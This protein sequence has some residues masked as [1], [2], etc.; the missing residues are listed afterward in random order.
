MM[1]VKQLNL[2]KSKLA[3]HNLCQMLQKEK[4]PSIFCLQEP[5]YTKNGLL[6]GIPK[7]Y[8]WFGSSNSRGII[9]AH[10]SIDLIYSNEFSAEDI[11]VCYM[12]SS[13]RFF[14]SIYLDIHKDPIHP[15]MI[16]MAEY[17]AVSKSSALLCLDSNAHSEAFWNSFDT[18]ARGESIELFC[19]TYN[20]YVLNRGS[21][22]TFFNSRYSSIIDISLAFNKRDDIEDWKV[23]PECYT[24]SDH[25]LISMKI[26]GSPPE[27]LIPKIDW[28]KFKETIKFEPV[29]YSI[30]DKNTIEIESSRIENIICSNLEKC[31]KYQ[32]AKSSKD[33]WF[34]EE[35]LKEKQKVKKLFFTKMRNPTVDNI[36][37]YVTAKKL[38]SK[39]IRISKRAS[40]RE[41]CEKI[42]SPKNVSKLNRIIQSSRH[43]DI[44][45]LEISEGKY[46]KSVKETIEV[47]M[48]THLPGCEPARES[49]AGLAGQN[50]HQSKIIYDVNFD[51]FINEEKV[52]MSFESLSPLKAP[53]R[54]GIKVKALQLIGNDGIKRITN[55]YKC[56]VEIGYTPSN[57]LI[58]NLVFLPKPG[59]SDYKKAKSYRGISLMQT[60]LKG[61]ERILLWE[62]QENTLKDNPICKSQYGFKKGTST[63][64]ALSFFVDEVERAILRGNYALATFC[65]IEGAFDNVKFSSCIKALEQKNF[66]PKILNWYNHYLRNRYAE[67]TILG[68]TVRKKV[69]TGIQ[70]GSL[71][72][73]LI[74]NVYFEKWLSLP[75]GPVSSKAFCDDGIMVVTGPCSN[76]L[77]DLMQTAINSTM[78]FGAQENL[79]FNPQKTKIMFFHRKNKFKF[80]KKLKMSGVEIEYSDYV[81]YL[82]VTFDTRLRFNKHIENKLVKAKKHLMLLRNAITTTWGPSPRALKWGYNGI[83][84]QSF[85]YGSNVAARACRTKAVQEK[86][87]KLNRL[88][89]CCMV[90]MR[91]STPTNGLEVI[92]DLPPL[93]L[94]VEERA[95]Q[96]MLRVLPQC[97][98]KW[99]GIGKN[100][101]VGHLKW[102]ANELKQMDIDPFHNDTCP[103]TL[104]ISR[105]Y[106]VDLDSFKSGLPDSE[107]YTNCYSDGSKQK[108]GK[109]GYGLAV[110][111]GDIMIGSA[112]AQL[113]I[114]NS[115]FQA[116][117][118]AIDKS[119]Q[120]LRE[121]ETESVTIFSDS[122]SGLYALAGIQTKSKVVKNC[123]ENLNKLGETCKIELKWVKGHAFHT[124]NELADF[125]AKTGT[126]NESN[127][128]DLP[129]PKTIA[130]KKISDAMYKK[131]SQRWKSSTEFRQTKLFFPEIDRKKSEILGKLDRKTLSL[132]V[133][134]LTG[135]NRL[136]YHESK[137]NTMQE[138]SSCRFCQWEDET[139][140]H[141]ITECPAFWRS[142]MDIFGHTLLDCTPEWKV[143]QLLAFV[144]KT[145][146]EKLLNPGSNQ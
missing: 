111:R 106:K 60:L 94:K 23:H 146:M 40:W 126:K 63:E 110:T 88:I 41:F 90:S 98:S 124:G 36:D 65:D 122:M 22:P 96:T 120:L 53:G 102:A 74:W 76:T 59:K 54:D 68:E 107:T 51:S 47:L 103:A 127:K 1:F 78:D 135:H 16:E 92:L 38:Y 91:K 17:F 21:I 55:L 66:P 134:V 99:D 27:I 113:N 128:V 37:R 117:I 86:M 29:F 87:T 58:S 82:G 140:W 118:H 72:S 48:T 109:T 12:N 95:L 6:T 45:L 46:T 61:L 93:D 129:P 121:L 69:K 56:I 28:V 9:L 67:T 143:S 77:V 49:K 112:N 83:I 2:N 7:N 57:W 43:R 18:N 116:E 125:L 13:N 142:R 24:F 80:P 39:N 20:A 123:I 137:V 62:L 10:S 104:N 33:V 131:W 19:M 70:Q 42:D 108:N 15:K 85:L 101:E 138:D 130:K 115:V 35:L 100:K 105:K 144:Q 81:K 84:L 64:H 4:Q 14:A 8:R 139:S 34:T 132:M 97:S 30:W 32:K 44:E 71:L 50:T 31:T 11:T 89:A 75:M 3:W 133:Q 26:G 141:L 79:I 136:N 145:K 73:P 52:K 5:Y 114:L 119:C 25:R